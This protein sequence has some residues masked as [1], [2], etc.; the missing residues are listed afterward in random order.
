MTYMLSSCPPSPLRIGTI[1][2]QPAQA[3]VDTFH[4]QD[5]NHNPMKIVVVAR[6]DLNWNSQVSSEDLR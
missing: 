3:H 4:Q 2:G 6:E 1:C 5:A